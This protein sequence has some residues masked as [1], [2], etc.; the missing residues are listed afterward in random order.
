MY[1]GPSGISAF[2]KQVEGDLSA[3]SYNR[4]Q[5]EITPTTPKI[6]HA[7]EEA[8]QSAIQPRTS[9]PRPAENPETPVQSPIKE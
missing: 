1:D 3:I 2:K 4:T 8:T 9:L 5:S 7:A 6:P